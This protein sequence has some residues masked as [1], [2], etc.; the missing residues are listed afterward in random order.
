MLVTLDF[1]N[2]THRIAN[3]NLDSTAT[4][5][6]NLVIGNLSIKRGLAV[7]SVL[8]TISKTVLD[9]TIDELVYLILDTPVL[10][11]FYDTD[12]GTFKYGIDG[13]I[14]KIVTKDADTLS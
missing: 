7:D 3:H 10:V 8:I 11:E 6:S 13:F 12:S 1:F 2:G 4:F 14:S 9:F 5:V